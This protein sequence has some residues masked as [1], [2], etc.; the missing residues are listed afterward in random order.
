[1]LVCYFFMP[2]PSQ[3]HGLKPV[4]IN[5]VYGLSEQERQHWMPAW[6]WLLVA[7]FGFPLALY[8]PAHLLLQ[9]WFSA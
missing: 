9:H 4:N 7:L 3:Q 5:Y 1:M 6:A 2:P 8:L